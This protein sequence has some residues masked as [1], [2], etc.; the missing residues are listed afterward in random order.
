M[1]HSFCRNIVV[2]VACFSLSGLG[3]PLSASAGVVGT[4]A[5]LAL[6]DRDIRI[7]RIYDALMQDRVHEQL[8]ALGVDPKDAKQRVAA[9]TDADLIALDKRL[10]DLPA[11]G[12]VLEAVVVVFLIMLILDLMG[13]T[14]IFPGIGPGKTK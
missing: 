3:I 13:V 2:S 8:T 11:G 1:Y 5:Y 14:D 12:S 9:L 4:A 10:Q 7:E 6:Q